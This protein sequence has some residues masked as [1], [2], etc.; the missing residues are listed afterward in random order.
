MKIWVLLSSV[1]SL[2]ILLKFLVAISLS[3]F[4]CFLLLRSIAN[5]LD[6]VSFLP[7][8]DNLIC[9]TTCWLLCLVCLI[10]RS[11]FSLKFLMDNVF[12]GVIVLIIIFILFW[13][14]VTISFV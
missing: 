1:L 2:A 10:N 14:C 3:V 7:L 5:F 8:Y 11:I 6:K 13:V 4:I 9:I 12:L